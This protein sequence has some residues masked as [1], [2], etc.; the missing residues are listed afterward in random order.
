MSFKVKS[1]NYEDR[2]TNSQLKLL[3]SLARCIGRPKSKHAADIW[4]QGVLKL[5]GRD[6]LKAWRLKR[7]SK[8]PAGAVREAA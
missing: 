2:P 6:E 1:E 3:R 8:K 7:R 4:I 5:V